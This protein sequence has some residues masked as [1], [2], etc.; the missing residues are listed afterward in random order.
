MRRILRNHLNRLF[1]Q[2]SSSAIDLLTTNLTVSF[3]AYRKLLAMINCYKLR[4]SRFLLMNRRNK[5]NFS[6]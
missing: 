2:Y 5:V 1:L 4:E 6:T 3:V